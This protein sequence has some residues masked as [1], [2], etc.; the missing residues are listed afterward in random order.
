M[1]L[2]TRKN[3]LLNIRLDFSYLSRALDI[4]KTRE[5]HSLEKSSRQNLIRSK[6]MTSLKPFLFP[7]KFLMNRFRF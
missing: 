3:F 2:S 7:A 5:G 1:E 4:S 6:V